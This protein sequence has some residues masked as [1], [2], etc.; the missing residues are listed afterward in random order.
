MNEDICVECSF[1]YGGREDR[2]NFLV[3]WSKMKRLIY[4]N[5]AVH[6]NSTVVLCSTAPLSH[7]TICLGILR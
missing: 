6:I 3:Y 4:I 2:T 7:V 5:I 1:S